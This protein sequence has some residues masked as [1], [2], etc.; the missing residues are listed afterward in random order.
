[1]LTCKEVTELTSESLDGGL[2]IRQRIA[3]RLHLLTCKFCSR[4]KRQLVFM[5]DAIR[6]YAEKI[7]DE[8][9]FSMSLSEE[10]CQRI[11]S[12]MSSQ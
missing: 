11:K 8:R 9:L 4:Y 2:P 10:S 1:M 5:R 12:L 6:Q 7:E 3:L